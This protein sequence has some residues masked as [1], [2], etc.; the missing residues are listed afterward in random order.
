MGM[1]ILRCIVENS[2]TAD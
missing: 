2:G 1:G